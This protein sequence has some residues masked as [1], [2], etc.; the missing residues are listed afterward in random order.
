[1]EYTVLLQ[2]FIFQ[3]EEFNT[4]VQ[5]RLIPLIAGRLTF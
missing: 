2:R 5:D 3:N 1:M 4:L